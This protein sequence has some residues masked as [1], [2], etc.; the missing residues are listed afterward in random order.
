MNNRFEHYT[1][2]EFIK[3]CFADDVKNFWNKFHDWQQGQS[4]YTFDIDPD[5]KSKVLYDA[6]EALWNK[7][8]EFLNLYNVPTVKHMAD[9]INPSIEALI[10]KPK[11]LRLGSD[12]IMSIYWHWFHRISPYKPMSKAMIDIAEN[13]KARDEY[14]KIWEELQSLKR[15]ERRYNEKFGDWHKFIWCYLQKANTIGGFVLFP[16]H[17]NSINQKRGKRPIDDRFDL[18][19]ECI[20]RMYDSGFSSSNHP[21]FDISEEDKEFF[22]MFGSFKEYAKFFCFEDSWVTEGHVLNLLDNKL[23]DDWDF[24]REPLPQDSK[25]WWRFYENIMNRLNARNEQIKKIMCSY[26]KAS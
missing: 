11:G 25:Q 1:A 19:L 20:R 3:L 17:D 14:Q 5:Q 10:A 21:L 18:T 24:S 15:E 12:S 23:L 4:F 2:E 16:R 9:E 6:H 22:R 8:R 7:Q 13:I 26:F